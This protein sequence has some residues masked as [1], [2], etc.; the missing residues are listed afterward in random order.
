MSE[1][2]IKKILIAN[3]G[4]IACRVIHTAKL[5]GIKT[6]V[7]YTPEEKN[8]KH[9]QMADECHDLGEGPLSETYLN[10]QKIIQICRDNK[11]DAIHPGYGFLSENADF[12]EL[13][14]KAGIIFIGPTAEH[15]N[16][17]GDKI[18]SKVKMQEIGVPVIPGYNGS[19]QSFENLKKQAKI[20][21]FP[22]LIKATAGGGGKGMRI[23]YKEEEFLE[24]LESAKSEAQKS[25]SNGDVLIEK[26]ITKPRHIEVQMMSDTHGNHLHFFERECSIQRRYQKIIEETPSVA[27]NDEIRNSICRDAQKIT[28][29]ISYRGAATVEFILDEDGKYY[30]LEM[31]TR[32]Q[33][34]HPIT[35]EVTGVD[36]VAMQIKVAQGKKLQIKQEEIFQRGHSIECRIYAED[37]E[38]NFFPT[39]G[40]VHIV[41]A[42]D[43]PG[44][45]LDSGILNGDEVTVN[46]DPMIAKLIVH[47]EDRPMAIAKMQSAL[48][49]F[50]FLG[51]KNN[52]L[53]LK[54]VLASE[55]FKRGETWTNFIDE[56]PE[57]FEACE[58]RNFK[59]ENSVYGLFCGG[60]FKKTRGSSSEEN[61]VDDFENEL[62]KFRN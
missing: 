59:L 29:S 58:K 3:R 56:H 28:S 60:N 17:M 25:F 2:T 41:G 20:I 1:S 36:L 35:E 22:V 61:L 23:V 7:L 51:L 18:T 57:L 12:C 39:T 62:L 50:P 47:A 13:V 19:D 38:N 53:Y 26:F 32:L 21:G 46:F 34:E 52:R 24:S 8:S 6:A 43:L 49:D 4:E 48:N 27:L 44:V 30:F 45:R 37:P 31:N 40:R 14:E 11:V 9:V 5:L 16:L 42:S 33:V 55:S 54:K 10:K 15:I